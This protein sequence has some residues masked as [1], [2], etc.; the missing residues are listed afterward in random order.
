MDK[1]LRDPLPEEINT[2]KFKAVW[3]CIKHW[4]IGLPQDITEDGNQLYSGATGNH[5]V[6]VLDALKSDLNSTSAL[7]SMFYYIQKIKQGIKQKCHIEITDA[8][9]DVS[10]AGFYIRIQ[11]K[12]YKTKQPMYV[13]KIITEEE[14][15]TLDNELHNSLI[16]KII[17]EA[18]Y[19]FREEQK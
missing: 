3:N 11:T 13:Q 8:D 5:V 10:G 16:N 4:D 9:V 2:L 18:N 15:I 14:I 7:K 6:A 1:K 19:Y 17:K 12:N